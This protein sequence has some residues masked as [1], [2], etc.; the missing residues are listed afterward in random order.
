[1]IRLLKMGLGIVI[2]ALIGG[3]MTH[4]GVPL[5]LMFG[6]IIAVIVFNRFKIQFAVPKYTLTFVQI[7][8][9]TSVGLMFNQVSLGQA[10]NLFLLL[11]MLVVCLAVQFS[12][13]YFWFHRKVGWTKQEA[14]LGS[15]PG[16]MAAI[17]ALTDHTHTP[18]QK[19]VISHTIRLII[20][21]LLAGVVV[22]SDGDPQP[23]LVLP[24]LTWQSSFWLL[25]IVLTGLG[26]GLVL[27]RMHVP[28]PFMLTS[29]GAATLIQSWLDI[30]L[31]F[32]VLITELSMVLIGMNI[33]NHF[34][35]FP[36]SSLIKNIYSSA[37]VVIINIFLTLLITVFASWITGYPIP[38][39]LLA[40]APGSMEA[41]TFAAITMNLDAGFVMSNHIIRMVIIQSIPSIAMF[42]QER[43]AKKRNS[44]SPD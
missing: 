20:L 14:M 3:T 41:M 22:G 19:I 11:I 31:N 24:S 27:Q 28:A 25:V 9:G 36:L 42:W 1:M 33:G 5:A 2:C 26:L 6:P 13:S 23:L 39:L 17:L 34:I 21:I 35:V 10:E 30:Q 44:S 37:Q 38:V 18:P 29:L 4:L 15:V 16:A 32:P 12:F 43:R 8:L 7:S 40:W